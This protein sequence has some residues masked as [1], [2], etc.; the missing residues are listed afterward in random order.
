MCDSQKQPQKL[1]EKIDQAEISGTKYI[2]LIQYPDGIIK[3][4]VRETLICDSMVIKD[5]TKAVDV[6]GTDEANDAVFCSTFEGKPATEEKVEHF[7]KQASH[8]TSISSP[9]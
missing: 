8:K 3:R 7:T 9:V 5:Q 2:R 1:Q 6:T 4:C